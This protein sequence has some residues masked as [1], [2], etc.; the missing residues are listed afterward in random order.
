M[1]VL[2]DFIYL[3][4][5]APDLWTPEQVADMVQ[6]RI[7]D[8]DGITLLGQTVLGG[9]NNQIIT[10]IPVGF[11]KIAVFNTA[12]DD[13]Q[14]VA[15]FGRNIPYGGTATIGGSDFFPAGEFLNT[16]PSMLTAQYQVEGRGTNDG[17][18]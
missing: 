10:G 8:S 2:V 11:V 3:Q 14:L 13:P 16:V 18:N 4:L 5:E 17:G 6:L 12:W 15:T 9:G 1:D 7:Y